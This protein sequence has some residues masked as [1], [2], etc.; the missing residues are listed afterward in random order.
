MNILVI[1]S[2]SSSI[3]YQIYDMA[4]TT[5]IMHG[6]VERIGEPTS[7]AT[8][9]WYDAQNEIQ[10]IQTTQTFADH[11]H[12]FRHI[13]SLLQDNSTLK[14]TT[15]LSAIGH[16]VVH[17]GETFE[18]PTLIDQHV[19]DH[20]Q[21][22]TALA[23]LHNPANLAGIEACRALF[24]ELPQVAVFDTAFHHTMPPHAFR[25]AVPQ[26]WYHDH[27]VR[28]YGFHGTSH[29]YVA[30]HAARFLKTPLASLNLITLHLGNGA[31]AAAIHSGRCVDTSMGFTPLE[32]LMMGTRSGDID[33]AIP[34]YIARQ[35]GVDID[36]VENH[37]NHD[38]GLKGLCGENDMRE[39]QRL[40]ASGDAQ[41]KLAI[42]IYCYRV[43]KYIG[44]YY[45]VLGKVDAIV[46][47]AGVGEHSAPI[48]QQI[49]RG[50]DRLGIAL[51]E[52]K[53]ARVTGPAEEIQHHEAAIKLLVIATNEEIEIAHQTM[54]C[55]APGAPA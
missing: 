26:S 42:D 23:P 25:Y 37:L 27:H 20:I 15:P 52:D 7:H 9:R 29:A 5:A 43:R 24:P 21:R 54:S 39:V 35:T 36:A 8:H 13:A 2:G 45:A 1:N 33:P 30:K 16:R 3:K 14:K 50:L 22:M 6:W 38:S 48:R 12:A 11:S 51:D 44:A 40:A 47:T 10:E 31:S 4:R 18:A 53:N 55:L 19:I 34:F 41:A 49:C 28:R 32:G 17:G 46:F